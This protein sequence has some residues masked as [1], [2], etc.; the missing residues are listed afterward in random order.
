MRA[1]R[2]KLPRSWD[3]KWTRQ[4]A[5]KAYRN[6]EDRTISKIR[7]YKMAIIDPLFSILDCRECHAPAGL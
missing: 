1:L 2:E 7:G 4:A 3:T 6:I 5:E